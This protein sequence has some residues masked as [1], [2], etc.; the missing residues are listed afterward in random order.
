MVESLSHLGLVVVVV[1]TEGWAR[2]L[3]QLV[4]EGT[5]L[6][7]RQPARTG[8]VPLADAVSEVVC[9]CLLMSSLLSVDVVVAVVVIAEPWLS[10]SQRSDL[11]LLL[12][13]NYLNLNYRN[14]KI[15]LYFEYT[16]APASKRRLFPSHLSHV[17]APRKHCASS[18]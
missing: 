13:A 1:G 4:A 5:A 6:H 9:L 12:H 7:L 2:V 3:R 10:L 17:R 18:A 16:H 14:L 8:N 15:R 11:T